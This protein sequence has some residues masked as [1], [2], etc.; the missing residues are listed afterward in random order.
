MVLNRLLYVVRCD[1]L[2]RIFGKCYVSVSGNSKLQGL[3]EPIVAEL[4]YI[5][6]ALR[7]LVYAFMSII[8]GNVI[9]FC[10]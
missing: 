8:R 4:Y 9:C 3:S 6:L 1:F 2:L 10:E 5:L 7:L